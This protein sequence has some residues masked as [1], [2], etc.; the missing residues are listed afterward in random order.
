MRV[1]GTGQGGQAPA[2]YPSYGRRRLLPVSK[3]YGNAFPLVR[4]TGKLSYR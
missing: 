3:G 1:V 4:I 2:G